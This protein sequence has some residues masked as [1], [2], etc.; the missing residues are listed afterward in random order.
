M[1]IGYL[2][3]SYPELSQTF[4]TNEIDELRQTGTEVVVVSVR[5][6]TA[7]GERLEIC[8]LAEVDPATARAEQKR[9]IRSH[10]LRYARFRAR[11]ANLQ[12]RERGVEPRFRWR[13]LLPAATAL[14]ASGAQHLHAHFAWDGAAAA[15]C[16]APLLGIRWSVTL[17]A[18]DIF[19]ERRNLA[20]KLRTANRLVTVCDYNLDFMRSELHVSRPVDMVI[21][22][23]RLP[24]DSARAPRP[25]VDIVAVGRLVEKKGFDLLVGAL[26][27]LRADGHPFTAAIVGVGPE[28][29]RLQAMVADHAITGQVTFVGALPHAAA[30]D[31]IA[32][33]RLFVLPARVASTGDRDS[34]PVVLKEAM[35]LGIPVVG[36]R[37][38]AIPEMVDSQVG[39]IVPPDDVAS[40]AAAISEVLEL[41]EPEQRKLRA[42]GRARVE[43]KFLLE[44]EVR[45]LAA[46]FADEVA[47]LG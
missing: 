40:L 23:V 46:V 7:P 9:W 42:K 41:P 11:V 16:L 19:A 2:L 14:E 37:V 17:H 1:K 22:G 47:K 26:A 38:A 32:S 18:N 31:L 8:C 6:P 30:L 39:R 13:A 20:L 35:A 3:D 44:N 24:P 25:S 33:A 45:K 28:L 21:C 27:Q 10:P 43:E 34:M 12:L 5:P 29:H 15:Y 4:V 36:T